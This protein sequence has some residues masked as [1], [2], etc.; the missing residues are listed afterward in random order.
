MNV[1]IPL[2]IVSIRIMLRTPKLLKKTRNAIGMRSIARGVRG[3]DAK[4]NTM[5]TTGGK[6]LISVCGENKE[7]GDRNSW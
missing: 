7:K 6:T 3:P 5:R 4:M 2:V 1:E